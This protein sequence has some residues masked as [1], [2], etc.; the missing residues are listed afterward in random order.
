MKAGDS[1]SQRNGTSGPVATLTDIA[2]WVLLSLTFV[3]LYAWLGFRVVK[4][5]PQVELF[6]SDMDDW[7]GLQIAGDGRLKTFAT[8]AT[9]RHPLVPLLALPVL[10]LVRT[11]VA[12]P[13]GQAVVT[14]A[15]FGAVA[16][17]LGYY[18]LLL[19]GLRRSAATG[20][21]ALTGLSM[22]YA[23]FGSMPE[24]YAMTIAAIAAI[25]LLMIVSLVRR[26]FSVIAWTAMLVC[27][28]GVALATIANALVALAGAW[29][30]LR[31]SVGCR[32]VATTVATA[33]F[34][35]VGGVKVQHWLLGTEDV[36]SLQSWREER[37]DLGENLA[38][39]ASPIPMTMPGGRLE[40]TLDDARELVRIGLIASVVGPEPIRT[41]RPGQ[42][43]KIE[44]FG[45]PLRF[46]W[47]GAGAI[48]LWVP[49][50]ATGISARLR[51]RTRPLRHEWV[52]QSG[53]AVVLCGYAAL[54][55]AYN[56]REMFLY[57]SLWTFTLILACAAP[58]LY[59]R[60]LWTVGLWGLVVLVG[61]SNVST[62]IK[63]TG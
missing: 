22:S 35:L 12:D 59:T 37:R 40:R 21:A 25:Y 52:W 11:V 31:K 54:L 24:T 43:T 49:L 36:A 13:V 7:I 55:V 15:V 57:T 20:F 53:I 3:V 29:W 32:A 30:L 9:F 48:V 58:G 42:T 17:G 51:P 16:V 61:V 14:N 6:G 19:T 4:L 23:V 62:I 28:A 1:R 50:C 26:R 33:G 63:M 41:L 46:R 45:Y 18:V 34:L 56:P 38:I 47:T 27:S 39:T 5:Y 2:T 60:R 10:S 8:V 44:Y